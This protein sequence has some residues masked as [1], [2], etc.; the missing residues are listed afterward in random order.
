M[1]FFFLCINAGLLSA[2]ATTEMEKH[3]GFWSSYL[4]AFCTFLVGFVVLVVGK[5]SHVVRPPTG[6]I[7]PKAF[8]AMWIGVMSGCSMDVA[9]SSRQEARGRK[10]ATPCD[11]EFTDGL[12]RALVACRVSIFFPIYC[13]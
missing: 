1:I 4:L 9:K 11:D 10:Y 7:M 13:M 6:S 3:I 12:K 5:N 2:I 8:K